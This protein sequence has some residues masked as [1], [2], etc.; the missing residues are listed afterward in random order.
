MNWI[1]NIVKKIIDFR[2]SIGLGNIYS[3]NFIISIV[4]T[5]TIVD[6]ATG[7]HAKLWQEAQDEISKSSDKLKNNYIDLDPTKFVTFPGVVYNNRLICFSA[8]QMENRWGPN[9]ARCSTRMW[10]H[11]DYRFAGMTKFTGGVKFLNTTYCLPIQFAKAKELGLDCIFI[12]R[13][14]NPRAFLEYV[15]LVK[16]N[17]AETFELLDSMVN[18]CGINPVPDSCRQYVAVNYLTVNGQTSWNNAMKQFYL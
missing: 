8:L 7:L 18:V 11:P 2:H 5:Y 4:M 15:K 13:E 3:S 10:I 14:D 17:T 9:I 1:Q 16:I 12:S 6:L